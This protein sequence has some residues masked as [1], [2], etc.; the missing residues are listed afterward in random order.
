MRHAAALDQ[1]AERDIGGAG[2]REIA[3]PAVDGDEIVEFGVEAQADH[4]RD[5]IAS[6]RPAAGPAFAAGAVSQAA[7]FRYRQRLIDPFTY[8]E[9]AMSPENSEPFEQISPRVRRLLL[10]NGLTTVEEVIACHRS[11]ELAKVPLLGRMAVEEVENAFLARPMR[12]PYAGVEA[13]VTAD[14]SLI[15]ELMHP[16]VHGNRKQSLA[17]ATVAAGASTR[18]HRHLLS[19]EIYHVTA[20]EGEMILGAESFPIR[21]GDT[22]CIAPRTPHRV[23]ASASGPLILLCCCSPAYAH[24]DTE[25]L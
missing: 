13:Y 12:Q 3:L 22:I 14:G 24:T 1:V 7:D 8:R 19:E 4:R 15:R 20:G 23:S 16:G 9:H 25:L 18:L 17:E 6:R 21:R 10:V 5:S 11:G 2:E